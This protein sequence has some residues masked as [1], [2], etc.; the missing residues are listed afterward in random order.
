MRQYN[1]LQIEVTTRCNRACK[2]CAIGAGKRTYPRGSMSL[3][4]FIHIADQAQAM[5]VFEVVPFVNGEP[6]LPD[7]STYRFFDYMDEIEKRGFSCRLFTTGIG[8]TEGVIARLASYKSLTLL[9]VSI[10]SVDQETYAKRM[11]GGSYEL[12]AGNLRRAIDVLGKRVVAWSIYFNTPEA[13]QFKKQWGVNADFSPYWNYGGLVDAP[14]PKRDYFKCF[15]INRNSFTIF[16]DGTVVLCCQDCNAEVRFGNA[17]ERPLK[18]LWDE[19]AAKITAPWPYEI[20][21]RCNA[22]ML[23]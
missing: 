1:L 13:N 7:T 3:D 22:G 6:L 18:E 4:K 14:Y 2:F 16:W 10:H 9:Y 23:L 12:V 5:G 15:L 17:F 19:Y 21:R 20:C 11:T 8:L